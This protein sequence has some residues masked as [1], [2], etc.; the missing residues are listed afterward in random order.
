LIVVSE[1]PG[2][3]I[4]DIFHPGDLLFQMHEFV[5]LLLIFGQGEFAL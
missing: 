1:P 5:G 3:S 4:D 2:I